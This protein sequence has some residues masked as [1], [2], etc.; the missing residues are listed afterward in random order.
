MTFLSHMAEKWQSQDSNP[1]LVASLVTLSL[2]SHNPIE[3]SCNFTITWLESQSPEMKSDSPERPGQLRAEQEPGQGKA[4][5]RSR[6]RK[7]LVVKHLIIALGG[8]L[9]LGKSGDSLASC[10]FPK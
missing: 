2:L 1:D 4:G 3:S 10:H 7:L 9:L 5:G 6:R 8:D